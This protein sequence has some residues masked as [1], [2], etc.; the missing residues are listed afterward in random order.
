M[1]NNKSYIGITFIILIF[2]IF[3]IPKIVDRVSNNTIT[4]GNRLNKVKKG[5]QSNCKW[6]NIRLK[7]QG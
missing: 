1:N 2:G 7:S 4:D 6:N 5:V 3:A